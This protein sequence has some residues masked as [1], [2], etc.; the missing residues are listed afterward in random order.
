MTDAELYADEFKVRF[1]KQ[2]YWIHWAP[3]SYIY[4]TVTG[5][6]KTHKE[7]WKLA[8]DRMWDEGLV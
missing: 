3:F 2:K 7:A 8:L 1:E 5:P 4:G 6:F